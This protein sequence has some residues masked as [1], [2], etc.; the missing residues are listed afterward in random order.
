MVTKNG[1]EIEGNLSNVNIG[2]GFYERLL[3]ED[4]IKD[5]L[6]N[7]YERGILNKF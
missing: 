3:S 7:M 5:A 6:R 4:Q 1:K 2:Q